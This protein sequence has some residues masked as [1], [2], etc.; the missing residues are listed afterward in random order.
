MTKDLG[1]GGK[2]EDGNGSGNVFRL[3]GIIREGQSWG[4]SDTNA[5]QPSEE[6]TIMM[7]CIIDDVESHIEEAEKGLLDELDMSNT[8]MNDEDFCLDNDVTDQEELNSFLSEDSLVEVINRDGTVHYEKMPE[9]NLSGKEDIEETNE[10]NAAGS[11]DDETEDLIILSTPTDSSVESKG[12]SR[13]N[14]D[15]R[16]F[17]RKG[18]GENTGY[19]RKDRRLKETQNMDG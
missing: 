1:N 14:L 12:A 10:D 6:G 16:P 18:G 13:M 4:R 15:A 5:R 8:E 7:E 11:A 17:Y 9:E 19:L 3:D 2:K